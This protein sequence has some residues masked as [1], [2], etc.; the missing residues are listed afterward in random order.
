MI[1]H[2]SVPSPGPVLVT[3]AGGFVGGHLMRRLGMGEGDIATDVTTDFEA[4]E[5]VRKVVW[6]LP[7]EAPKEIGEVRFIVHL[8]AMSSVSRSLREVHRAYEINLMG[9]LSVLEYMVARCPGARLLLASSAEVYRSCDGLITES[10]GI[11]PRNPYGTTKAAAETAAFQ[12]AGNHGLDIVVTR[13]FPHFGPGQSGGFVLPSFCRRILASRGSG[14]RTI[15]VGNLKPVRD[16]LYVTDVTSAYACILS[17]GR[18]GSIYNVCT[19]QGSSIEDMARML[20]GISGEDL[21]LRIDPELFRPADVEFQVGD[22]SRVTALLGWSPAVSREE[23]L[24]MLFRW[25]EEKE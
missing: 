18:S 25:W 19:G 12:Y 10:S 7:S 1:I 21:D 9:T 20:I 13:A 4:P 17:R 24:R 6:N 2:G 3:G 22:A 23:G 11:G 16:Y 15:R 14:E 5:G 8:A